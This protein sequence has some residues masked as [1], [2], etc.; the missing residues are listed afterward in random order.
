MKEEESKWPVKG[1]ESD[2]VPEL[3]SNNFIHMLVEKVSCLSDL[4]DIERFGNYMKLLRST[5]RVIAVFNKKC[6]FVNL[7]KDP[8]WN[9]ISIAQNLWIKDMQ[10][11]MVD[12]IAKG[13]LQRL[14]P[15]LNDQGIY[16]VSGR[17]EYWFEYT[18]N[19]KG[20]ILLPH[21][22]RFSLLYATFIH[23]INH[24]GVA[25]TVSKVR[26]KFWIVNLPRLVKG[27]RFKCVTCRK[28]DKQIEKQIMAPLPIERLKPSPPFN[29]TS[30]DLF[31]P[32]EIRGEVNKRSKGKVF[33][34]IFTCLSTR[35]IF[36]DVAQNYSTDAFLLVLRRFVSV[37]GYPAKIYSDPGTQLVSAD[38][39]LKEMVKEIVKMKG[40]VFGVNKGVE[41]CFSSPD[42][43]RQ[44]GTA[45]SLIKSVKRAMMVSIGKQIIRFSELQTVLFEVANIVNERPIGIHPRNPEDGK[46]LCPNDLLLGRSSNSVPSGPFRECNNLRR[47]SFVQSLVDA[48]WKKWTQ[49]YFSSLIIRPKWHT[50]KRNLQINDIVLIQDSNILRG[51]WKLGRVSNIYPSND[52]VVRKVEVQYKSNLE[53]KGFETIRRPVQRL[54]LIQPVNELTEN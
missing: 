2:D 6:S 41:W 8:S 5:A 36:C 33:G 23:N 9:D 19:D 1:T 46:Y 37:H 32:L 53:S 24:S 16:I 28:Q 20:L 11:S 29:Y 42:A 52:G 4:I 14:N 51:N 50:C 45:E 34:V 21:E 31:G 13:K 7:L 49:N 17:M 22:H 43:S 48:F 30:L 26:R 35:A 54:V 47:L 12:V 39:E 10:K 27:I 40:Y 44:N 18:Y 15:S 25:A 3:K 38:K